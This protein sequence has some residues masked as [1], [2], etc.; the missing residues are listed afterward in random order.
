MLK[1]PNFRLNPLLIVIHI[2]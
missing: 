2:S 1:Q